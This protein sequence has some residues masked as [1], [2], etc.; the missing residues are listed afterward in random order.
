MAKGLF[1]AGLLST[2]AGTIGRF[3]G[4]LL[5]SACAGITGCVGL[6]RVLVGLSWASCRFLQQQDSGPQQFILFRWLH[7]LSMMNIGEV[8]LANLCPCLKNQM[9]RAM[10]VIIQVP[11]KHSKGGPKPGF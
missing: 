8:S 1:N 10:S 7:S 11:A 6:C 4:N 3:M 9:S 5:L 2:Q